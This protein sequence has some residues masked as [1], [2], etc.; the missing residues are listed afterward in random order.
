MTKKY[1]KMGKNK[2]TF[3]QS[4]RVSGEQTM[5]AIIQAYDQVKEAKDK[6][7]DVVLAEAKVAD[8]LMSNMRRDTET[9]EKN[10]EKFSELGETEVSDF[11]VAT[12]K[13]TEEVVEVLVLL[14]EIMVKADGIVTNVLERVRAGIPKDGSHD[15]YKQQ[16]LGLELEHI[17]LMDKT[18]NIVAGVMVDM[19]EV[20][21]GWRLIANKFKF[22]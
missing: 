1:S 4:A 9:W 18:V 11:I 16:L 14:N 12:E 6:V 2:L 13:K 19:S 3:R 8:E 5:V 22:D 17:G 7:I 21:N 15:D 10:K 20:G